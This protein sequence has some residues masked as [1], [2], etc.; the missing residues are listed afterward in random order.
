VN[1]FTEAQLDEIRKFKFANLLC[2]GLGFEDS[3]GGNVPECG[4][5]E[6]NEGIIGDR[7]KRSIEEGEEPLVRIRREVSEGAVGE[8]PPI[9]NHRINCTELDALNLD[10]WRDIKMVVN[11]Y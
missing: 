8:N 2:I 9:I 11:T 5:Y 6:I 1:R 7:K 10:P 3:N 4:F